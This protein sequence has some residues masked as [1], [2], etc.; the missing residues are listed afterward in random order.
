MADLQI[1]V[2]E[3]RQKI[4]AMKN[5]GLDNAQ[6]REEVVEGLHYTT[7]RAMFQLFPLIANPVGGTQF[8]LSVNKALGAVNEVLY[9][10]YGITPIHISELRNPVVT[11]LEECLEKDIDTILS[12]L[13]DRGVA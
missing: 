12:E 8:V 10:E 3:A 7:L 5:E 13:A 11:T 4:E 2:M 9:K 6:I 1:V